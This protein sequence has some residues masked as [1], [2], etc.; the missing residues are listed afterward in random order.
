MVVLARLKDFI[1]RKY[2]N[3]QITIYAMNYIYHGVLREV[4]DDGVFLEPVSCVYNTGSHDVLDR[5]ADM[6]MFPNGR[7]I[8]FMAM[9]SG[10]I[11]S[12]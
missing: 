9:E 2:G 7:F 6:R 3:K 8:P 10:G 11:S 4:F 12:R 1:A 5:F